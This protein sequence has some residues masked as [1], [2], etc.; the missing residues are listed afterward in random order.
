MKE[1]TTQ[2]PT[3]SKKK[4]S[5]KFKLDL[6]AKVTYLA[7][8]LKKHFLFCITHSTRYY[9]KEIRIFYVIFF[10]FSAQHCAKE[11]DHSGSSHGSVWSQRSNTSTRW[12]KNPGNNNIANNNKNKKH[13]SIWILER[14]YDIKTCKVWNIITV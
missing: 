7:P 1:D 5:K 13:L 6:Q 14:Y 3:V 4:N 10:V 2:N 12:K 8:D 11:G 9:P